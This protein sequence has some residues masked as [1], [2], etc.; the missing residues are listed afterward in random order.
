MPFGTSNSRFRN[1]SVKGVR[2]S[3]ITKNKSQSLHMLPTNSCNF[4]E[5]GERGRSRLNAPHSVNSAGC[6]E[7]LFDGVVAVW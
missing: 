2:F 4:M 3:P 1:V 5:P 6:A 7:Q